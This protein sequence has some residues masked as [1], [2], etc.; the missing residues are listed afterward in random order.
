MIPLNVASEPIGSW[1]ATALAEDDLHH[2]NAVQEI[3]A[4][5]IHLIDESDTG[6]M[7][8]FSL[9]PYR[10]RLRFYAAFSR[11]YGNRA[12]Q[13]AKRTFNFNC[14]VNVPGVSMM[15]IR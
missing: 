6:N 12:V 14:K 9:T 4:R 15:L 2:L 8:V 10:F 13:N 5:R 1:I 3:S 7:V 11:K